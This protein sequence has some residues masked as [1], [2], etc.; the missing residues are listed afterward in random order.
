MQCKSFTALNSTQH[1]SKQPVW[2]GAVQEPGHLPAGQSTSAIQDPGSRPLHL[3]Q[4]EN[5]CASAAVAVRN[6]ARKVLL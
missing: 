6:V 2:G 5:H 1:L 4:T 3:L